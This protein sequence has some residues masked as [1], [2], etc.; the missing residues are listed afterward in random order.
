M[1]VLRFRTGP[2]ATSEWEFTGTDEPALHEMLKALEPY[3][4]TPGSEDAV[5]EARNDDGTA[6]GTWN[7]GGAA[8]L[9]SEMFRERTTS[10]WVDVEAAIQSAVMDPHPDDQTAPAA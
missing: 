8:H 4:A 6:I 7:R 2:S 3:A 1:I 10:P 9:A 5:L